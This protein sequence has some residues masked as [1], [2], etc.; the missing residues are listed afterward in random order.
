MFPSCRNLIIDL[1]CKSI[2]WSLYDK[3]WFSYLLKRGTT[4]NYL[5][6][7]ETSSNQPWYFLLKISYS[8]V[9]FVLILHP[10]VLFW[11]NLESKTQVVQID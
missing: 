4:S 10:K 7:S 6:P 2:D 11:A 1:K 3:H 8:Q 5:K 9:A